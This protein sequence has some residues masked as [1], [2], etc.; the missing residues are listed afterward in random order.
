MN[1]DVVLL[2]LFVCGGA[3]LWGL[4]NV[5]KSHLLRGKNVHE[6]FMAVVVFGA[7][8]VTAFGAEFL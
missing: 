3:L 6:D 8:A 2:F 7:A 4:S 1:N 5:W